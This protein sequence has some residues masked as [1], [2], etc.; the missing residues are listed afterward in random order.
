MNNVEIIEGWY[1][2]MQ[3]LWYTDN[4][5]I[6]KICKIKHW[7]RTVDWLVVSSNKKD[8]LFFDKTMTLEKFKRKVLYK[9][10]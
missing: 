1:Y 4:L 6:V 9:V 5:Y 2:K 7:F 10:N 8:D 3:W